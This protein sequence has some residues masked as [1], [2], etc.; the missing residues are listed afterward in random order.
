MDARTRFYTMALLLCHAVAAPALVTS[1]ALPAKPRQQQSPGRA[2]SAFD[3]FLAN[4]GEE[5]TLSAREQEKAGDVFTLRGDVEIRY[6]DYIVRAD[7]IRYDASTGDITA[8]GNVSFTGGPNDESVR[9]SR[10]EYNLRTDSGRFKDV[11]GT[12][13]VRTRGGAPMMTT[14]DPFS[15]T[16]ELV[17]KIGRN[18]YVVTNGSVTSCRLPDPKWTFNASKIVVNLRDKARVYNTT[19]RIKGVPVL[20]LPFAAYPTEGLSRKSG[21]LIPTAG[22]SSRKGTILGQSFYWAINRSMD[23]TLG[24]EY[25]SSRGWAQ[26]GEFR[27]RPSEKSYISA[28]VLSV[29]DRGLNTPAND[30]GGQDVKLNAEAELPRGV[31]G[32]ISANYLSSFVFRLA[33]TE[34]FSQAVNSEVKS[35]AF[36]VKHVNGYSFALNSARYQNFQSTARGDV[37]TIVRWPSLH[38]SSLD[39]PLGGTPFHW[40]LEAAAEGVSRREPG[41]VT[42]PAVGRFDV[43][44]RLSLPRFVRG[45]G[46]R[47]EVSLR[48]TF[49]TERRVPLPGPGVPMEDVVNRRSIEGALEVRPPALSRIFSRALLGR[50]V[51]H[52]IEP[53]LTYR[54]ANGVDN[55][56]SIIRFDARDILSDTNE[57]EYALMNR[58][59]L[60]RSNHGEAA[61]HDFITWELSQKY[62]IDD[63]FGGALVN[64]RRN[65][66]ATTAAFTGIAFLTEPRR[67]SPIVSKLRV[68]AGVDTDISW[69][70]DYDTKKG[71]LN[72]S[73]VFATHRFGDFFV[74]G[75][76]AFLQAPGEIFFNN[77]LPSPTRFNQ[78]RWLMGYGGPAKRGVSA[79]VN[80]GFD[81]NLGFLQYSA[82][83]T[84]YNWDC[85]GVSTEYRRFALGQVRNEN[86][87]RFAFTLANVGTFGNLKRQERLF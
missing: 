69:Q 7:S 56:Q 59:F 72:A 74:G 63:N 50:T 32:V 82:F 53:R 49:Y 9:A 5:V 2:T 19:F 31:R 12:T 34:T 1:Q 36:L 24:A 79:A 23:A 58:V 68:G 37:I 35:L 44:P 52:M 80:I 46:I 47:P 43:N 66:L 45:W 40:S 54:F 30:Q 22:A 41:F 75:S 71:R 28:N 11:V 6:G 8:E 10:A 87:F 39:R 60:R 42:S 25:Y 65:V 29:L 27:A 73:N 85:C 15:F 78:V 62:F 38:I 76:H 86:Q 14:T 51:K 21:F 83:Q 67:F 55:F 16:G 33:F 13:G 81:A 57:V 61:A 3:Q 48:N 20:Y 17:E 18:K 4:G 64:G 84:S 77:P 26:I 70:L